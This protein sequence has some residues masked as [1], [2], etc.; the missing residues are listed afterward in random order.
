M[1]SLPSVALNG[2]CLSTPHPLSS[3][4]NSCAFDQVAHILETNGVIHFPDPYTEGF[5]WEDNGE[6]KGGMKLSKS[7]AMQ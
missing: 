1:A 3:S 5:G 2:E 6:R 4:H 7:I